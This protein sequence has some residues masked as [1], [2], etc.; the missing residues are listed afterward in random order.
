MNFCNLH[1]HPFMNLCAINVG[2]MTIRESSLSFLKNVKHHVHIK[3]YYL[4]LHKYRVYS[5]GQFI[6]LLFS[7]SRFCHLIPLNTNTT[8]SPVLL[9][10]LFRPSQVY[11]LN[12]ALYPQNLCYYL[13]RL[14]RL[15]K[16]NSF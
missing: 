15:I 10:E 12:N 4:W 6:P 9:T 13:A 5:A 3:R 7:N 11:L 14:S 8:K 16:N 2:S 1:G